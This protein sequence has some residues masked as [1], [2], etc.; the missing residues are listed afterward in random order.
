MSGEAIPDE[1]LKKLLNVLYNGWFDKWRRRAHQLTD[2]ERAKALDELRGI[3]S[4]GEQ[5]PIAE[6]LS[7][8]FYAEIDA[9]SNGGR[10]A[11][12]SGKA[13]AEGFEE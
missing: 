5:Y 4:Q 12:F 11:L 3:V 7:L 1:K 8:A 10:Y 9:R 6:A 13:E 2:Q